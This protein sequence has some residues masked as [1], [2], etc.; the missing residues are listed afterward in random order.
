[1]QTF[2]WAI[3]D[4]A[5]AH[6]DLS[7]E[8]HAVMAVA[9]MSRQSVSPYEFLVECEGFSPPDLQGESRFVLRIAW[10]ESTAVSAARVWL[11][12]QPKPIVERAAVAVAAL[13]FSHLIPDGQMRVAE[14]GQRTDYWLPCLRSA[15]EIS[16][17]EQSRELPRR[18]RQKIA[19]M[20]ANPWQ[21]NGY[22]F[23]CCFS[24]ARRFIRWSYHTQEE[25][26][27]GSSQG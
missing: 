2:E 14:E 25:P 22:V 6:P 18:H 17:T 1:M 24:T 11:T 23:V 19:Q 10:G 3:E 16:G 8:Y 12:E 15:L 13:L 9:L 27:H 20:L 26:G 21:W 4:V 5:V 7:L